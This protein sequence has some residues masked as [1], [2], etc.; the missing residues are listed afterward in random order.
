MKRFLSL[1]LALCLLCLCACG[2]AAPV[3]ET[4]E[5]AQETGEPAAAESPAIDAPELAPILAEI[6]ERMHP[7]TAGSSLTAAQLAV[8]LLDWCAQTDW[9]EAQIRASVEDFLAPMTQRERTE[10]ALQLTSVS[11]AVD[12]LLGDGGEGLLEDI[13][14]AEGT[15]WP[16][17]DAPTEKLE[18]LFAAANAEELMAD[19][20]S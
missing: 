8:L 19:I 11:G 7:G 4:G 3:Q 20:N 16:W 18:A 17:T 9:D 14:G 5:P 1:I 12:A 6:S 2:T 13:G 10:F 15:L